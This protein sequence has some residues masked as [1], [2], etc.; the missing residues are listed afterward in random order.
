[1]DPQNPTPIDS[2]V[3]SPIDASGFDADRLLSGAVVQRADVGERGAVIK[4]RAPGQTSYL[5]ALAGAG[6]AIARSKVARPDGARAV[7]RLEGFRVSFVTPSAIALVRGEERGAIVVRGS[8]IVLEFPGEVDAAQAVNVDAREAWIARGLAMAE[9]VASSAIEARRADATRSLK[10]GLARLERRIAAVRGDM[11]RIG[12]AE[13]LAARAQWLV[14]E[15]ARAPRG[16]KSLTFTDWSTGEANVIEVP[17][18]PSKPARDQVQAMFQRARR[19]KLGAKIAE[20][21]LTQAT[22]ARDALA[23]SLDALATAVDLGAIESIVTAARAAAPK[24]VTLENAQAPSGK[25]TPQ[26]KSP[27]FRT[28]HARSGDRILVGRGAA[29]NDLLTFQVGR[30]HDLW[31]HAKDRTGAHVIA[32]LQKGH[33]CPPELLVDAAHLAAH[34]SEARDETIVDVQYVERRYIRKPRGSAPGLVVVDREKV[35]VLR[36]DDAILRALLESEE[37]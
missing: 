31:L 33:A 34:F 2:P 12:D 7:K 32:P 27:P 13:S 15:A 1:M 10:R 9:K 11:A 17:L 23:A 5:L 24:D 16:A 4:L 8:R 19:L 25:R 20:E 37:G 3:D 30:P 36:R 29:Q 22:R 14:A 6:M 35:I 18:D 21:R 28:F 26:A